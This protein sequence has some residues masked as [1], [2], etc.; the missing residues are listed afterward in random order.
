[1]KNQT[2]AIVLALSSLVLTTTPALAAKH[3]M[4]PSCKGAVVYAVSS[5][6]MYYMR[7]TTQ[8]GHVKGGTYMCKAAANARGYHM[9]PSSGTMMKSKEMNGKMNTMTSP[10]PKPN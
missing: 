3:G 2:T 6:H 8:Y 10:S 7:G 4:M 5:T 9:A 1:M